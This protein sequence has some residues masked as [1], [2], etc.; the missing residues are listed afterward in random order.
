MARA[1]IT[2]EDASEI[3]FDGT[4]SVCSYLPAQRSRMTYR[5]ALKLS[6]RRYES[7]LARGWRRFG[8]TIFRPICASCRACQSLR[9]IIPEFR[10]TKSQRRACQRNSALS[11]S[12][13]RPTVTDEHLDLYNRY[14]EDMHHRRDWPFRR[15]TPSQYIESFIDGNFPFAREFQYRDKG[16]LVGLGL[17]DMTAHA[18]SSVYFYHDPDLRNQSV[19]TYSVQQE[20]AEGLRTSRQWLYLGFYIRDC[21]SMNYKNRFGPHQILQQ[22]VADHEEPDWRLPAESAVG[23]E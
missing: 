14:H 22:F 4:A 6:E 21:I 15:I 16:R 1:E 17:V 2:Q 5:L 12:I 19:G 3:N 23:D 10:P 20:I 18:M 13:G 7:L 11:L 9:V 8:R